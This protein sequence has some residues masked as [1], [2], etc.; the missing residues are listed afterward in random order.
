M[1]RERGTIARAA[2]AIAVLAVSVTAWRCLLRPGA[3]SPP[4]ALGLLVAVLMA[5]AVVGVVWW[6]GTRAAAGGSTVAESR[7]GWRTHQAWADAGLADQL[8]VQGIWEEQ[9]APSG[10]TRLTIAWSDEAFELWHGAR[11]PRTVVSLGWVDVASVTMGSGNAASTARPAVVATTVAGAR[12]VLVP[13]RAPGGGLL[14]APSATVE[15]L[16]AQLGRARV[17]AI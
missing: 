4:P 1:N 9:L 3:D 11:A 6:R 2:T 15:E 12:L 7:P 8:A 14:P 17:A 16:V 10:G 5:A 13:A